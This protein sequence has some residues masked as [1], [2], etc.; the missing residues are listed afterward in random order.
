MNTAEPRLS[1]A[2]QLLRNATHID[3]VRLN[4]HPL[5]LGI[6]RPEYSLDMYGSVLRAY[7]QFYQALEAAIDRCLASLPIDFDYAPRRKLP[8]L[9]ADLAYFAI[10]PEARHG[11]IDAFALDSEAAL[12]GEG[13]G[14]R[15]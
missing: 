15:S 3:H 6:T 14:P 8:W 7:F 5:L 9:G 10:A 11:A 13:E 4:Q 12:V 1:P 2:R